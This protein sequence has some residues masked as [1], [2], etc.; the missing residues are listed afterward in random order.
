METILVSDHMKKESQL[1][2]IPM[3][4]FFVL[5]CLFPFALFWNNLKVSEFVLGELFFLLVGCCF[6]YGYLYAVHYQVTVSSEKIVLHTLF[7]RTEIE[8]KDI[9]AYTS[10]RYKKSEFYQFCIFTKGKEI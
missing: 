8:I 4:V 2:K 1:W 10:K 6:L 9:E 3:I 7:K 5:T